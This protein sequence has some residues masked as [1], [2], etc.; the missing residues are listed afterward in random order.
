MAG[1]GLDAKMIANT[2]PELKRRVGWL[3][4]V[5]AIGRSL[6]DRE[7]LRIRYRLDDDEERS[8][9]VHTIMVGNCGTM[10]GNVV[11]L[12]DAK[13]DDGIFDIVTLRPEG[14]FGWAQIWFKIFWENGVLRR[15]QVGRKI[16]SMQREV[17]TLRYLRGAS[18][19]VK[20]ERP[21]EFELDGDEFG[22]AVGFTAKVDP[23]GVLIRVPA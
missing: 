19:T 8:T 13:I 5:D 6:V 10:P 3:A 4:Y 17:R 9:R 1:L 18:I 15:S 2:R 23:K 21:E 20:L 12:P 7:V 11:L 16:V 22:L 14:F